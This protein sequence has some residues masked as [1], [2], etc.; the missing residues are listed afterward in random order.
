MVM[1]GA[2]R[3]AKTIASTLWLAQQRKASKPHG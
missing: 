3:D 1:N 2:I